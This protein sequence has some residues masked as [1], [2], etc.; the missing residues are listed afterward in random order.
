MSRHTYGVSGRKYAVIYRAVLMENLQYA[1]NI[2]MGFFGYFVFIFI[3]IKLW[4]YIY[5]I[6]GELIAGYTKVQ[7]IWYVM[8]TEMI[9]F[10]SNTGAVARQVSADIRGGNIAYLMNKPYHYTLYILA[11]YTRMEHSAAD[12]RTSCGGDR[13]EYGR[14]GS[15]LSNDNR[16]ADDTLYYFGDHH[17][18]GLQNMY[19]SD[20]FLD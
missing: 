9:W 11:K 16:F 3:F 10:G 14:S 19:Q 6:P 13:W 17:Q 15:G 20:F 7:M 5:R 4:D 18:C 8:V 2:A 1:A 12:V